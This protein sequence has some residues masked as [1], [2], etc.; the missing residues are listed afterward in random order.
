MCWCEAWYT[1][2]SK[3]SATT[4]Q[5]C[6]PG[7]VISIATG[8]GL[9]GPGI[10]SRWG[11][12]FSASVQ[13]GPGVHPASYMRG[14][15]SF[16]GVYWPGHGVDHQPSFS[17]E[18]KE[19]VQLYLCSSSGPSRPILGRTLPYSTKPGGMSHSLDITMKMANMPLNEG[20]CL[21]MCHLLQMRKIIFIL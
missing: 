2:F 19:R 1:G 11:A 10:E 3:L 4:L 15:R 9:D 7:S 20:T 14:T 18:V 16:P 5:K 21:H 13:I 8:Y 17:A 6:E 12:K